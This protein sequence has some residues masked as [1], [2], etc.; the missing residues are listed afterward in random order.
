MKMLSLTKVLKLSRLF[1]QDQYL[2]LKT[3]TKTLHLNTK[4]KILFFCPRDASK[5]KPCFRELH[6]LAAHIAS[7]DVA[8]LQFKRRQS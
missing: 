5:L 4:T 7:K 3:K 6:H 2:N 1:R 8:R